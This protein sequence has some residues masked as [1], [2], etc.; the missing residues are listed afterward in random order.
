MRFR[1][2]SIPQGSVYLFEQHIQ[3]KI[4]DDPA[5]ITDVGGPL[6][7]F[8]GLLIVLESQVE[9]C[10]FVRGSS[11]IGRQLHGTVQM[12]LSA[13]KIVALYPKTSVLIVKK[14]AEIRA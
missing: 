12:L 11:N 6:R 4:N 9:L 5:R 2:F 10:A 13:E 14:V 7:I 8:P 1:Q 3:L